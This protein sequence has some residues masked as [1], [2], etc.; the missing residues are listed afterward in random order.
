[1]NM[2]T[3]YIFCNDT[4]SKSTFCI[5]DIFGTLAPLNICNIC[6]HMKLLPVFFVTELDMFL[7]SF[8]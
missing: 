5:K 8:D 7:K 6:S 1:M 4:I 3:I 2:Y